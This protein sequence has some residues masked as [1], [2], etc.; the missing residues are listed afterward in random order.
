MVAALCVGCSYTIHTRTVSGLACIVFGARSAAFFVLQVLRF[1]AQ[2][3]DEE[4]DE[5][6][7][8]LFQMA[9]TFAYLYFTYTG[10]KRFVQLKADPSG[11]PILP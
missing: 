4:V 10:W 6:L 1:A 11:G 8:L 3:G 7:I 9:F 5:W 2:N